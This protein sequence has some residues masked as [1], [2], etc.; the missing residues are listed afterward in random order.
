MLP[1]WSGVQTYL[2]QIHIQD[3][4]VVSNTFNISAISWRSA[5]LEEENGENHRTVPS[6]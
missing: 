6:H 4:V 1:G 5:L 2:E 3:A